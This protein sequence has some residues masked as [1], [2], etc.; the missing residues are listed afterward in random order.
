MAGL[1]IQE[2]WKK[3]AEKCLRDHG[4]NV[5]EY[6]NKIFRHK[7]FVTI[8]HVYWE[9]LIAMTERQKLDDIELADRLGLGASTVSR[10][11]SGVNPPAADKFFAVVLLVLKRDLKDL[12]IGNQNELLFD[13]VRLQHERLAVDYYKPPS[14]SLDRFV[15]R[16]L[17][18][19][20]QIPA[21]NN[22]APNSG[23]SKAV[24]EAALKEAVVVINKELQREFDSR[25]KQS[26]NVREK[27]RKVGPEELDEWLA[28][29]G[30]PYTLFAM[31]CTRA[32]GIEDV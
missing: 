13:A 12:D 24:K 30:I 8:G 17:L 32:W 6:P 7:F 21:V 25:V 28:C 23:S 5:K 14:C 3:D 26:Q 22:L 19:L 31:G 9:H 27:A 16:L 18:R 15:F 20:M 29:W 10:W 11:T 2:L 4:V 1:T